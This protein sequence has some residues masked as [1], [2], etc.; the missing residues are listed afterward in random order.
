[1]A[2]GVDAVM[3]HMQVARADEAI[4]LPRGETCIDELLPG[5][6][7]MLIRD[8]TLDPPP[9]T[10]ELKSTTCIGVN[11]NPVAHEAQVEP[12][13][14]THVSRTVTNPQLPAPLTANGPRLGR[15]PARAE[16]HAADP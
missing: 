2:H 3:N 11:F 7:P 15:I 10:S 14:R 4:N 5:D 9:I 1:M 6:R 16:R 12:E 13:G 8:K